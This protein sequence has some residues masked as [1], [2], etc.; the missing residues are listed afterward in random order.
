MAVPTRLPAPL[1]PVGRPPAIRIMTASAARI[2]PTQPST[3]R[4]RKT[5]SWQ[6][7]AFFYSRVIPELN[8]AS[9]FYAKMLKKLRIY[10]ALRDTNDEVKPITSGL[11]VEL[12]DRIQDPG[13]GRSGILSAYGR[14]MFMIGDGYL[15]GR[16]LGKPVERWS[17]VNPDEL[18]ITEDGIAWKST[19]GGAYVP[20]P[21]GT[22][23]AYRMW[24]PD[25]EYS[26]EAESPMRAAIE[27]AEELDLLTKAVRSTAVTRMLNGLLKV[28]QELSFGS[29]EPG[30][31]DDPEANPFL[32][33]MLDHLE[34]AIENP[35][36]PEGAMPWIAEGADEFLAGL[37]WISL[38]DAQTDYMEKDLRREA[39]DRLAMGMDLPPEVLKG[40]AEANHWG[41]RQIMHDTW[42]THGSVVAEQFCDDL[43]DAYLRPALLAEKFEDWSRVV[44]AYDD[45]QVVVP[46]DRTDDADKAYDRGNVSDQEYRIM[47]GIAESGAP[48]EEEKRVYLAVKLRDTSFLKGTKYEVEEPAPKA[49]PPGPIPSTDNPAPPEDGPPAPGPAGVSRQESRAAIVRGA[50]ELALYR[51]REVAGSRIRQQIKARSRSAPELALIDGKSN[52]HAAALIGEKR[53]HAMGLNQPLALVKTGADGFCALLEGWGFPPEQSKVLGDMIVV[54]AAKTLYQIELPQLPPG[55]LS[56]VERMREFIVDQAIVDHNNDSLARLREM[57]PGVEIKG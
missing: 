45:S 51:C 34:S 46:P 25:P 27:I 6:Q 47:K 41:A 14:L 57:L 38:H 39:I 11:P 53:L 7:K 3:Y 4:E 32:Q 37:E 13:G 36:T 29:D 56:Q 55:F 22:T 49:A 35:G 23:E 40:M 10:P 15:F 52:C 16:D 54:Y 1:E 31:D 5:E 50:A 2:R 19:R 8:Y 26:G 24:S 18:Q 9:R 42:R 20:L 33:D 48:S 43:A 28:P 17:F 44:I 12:L 21:K 30:L